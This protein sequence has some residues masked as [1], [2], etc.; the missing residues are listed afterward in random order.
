VGKNEENQKKT[1]EWVASELN[2]KGNASFLIH[3]L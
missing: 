1:K 2:E 3:K